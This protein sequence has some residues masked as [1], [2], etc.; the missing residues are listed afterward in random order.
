MMMVIHVYPV[1]PNLSV[2]SN[3]PKIQN[4][5]T[6]SVLERSSLITRKTTTQR[7]S[8]FPW[9][10]KEEPEIIRSFSLSLFALSTLHHMAMFF[11]L[12]NFP[13]LIPHPS[14]SSHP[15]SFSSHS[16]TFHSSHCFQF[17]FRLFSVCL[18]SHK[19]SFLKVGVSKMQWNV[20][21]SLSLLE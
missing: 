2:V 3:L 8:R 1:D 16:L 20:S 7:M 9:K 4:K 19:L 18:M 6:N 5:N 12:P 17:T 10:G 13:H 14:F 11:P 15:L 21:L